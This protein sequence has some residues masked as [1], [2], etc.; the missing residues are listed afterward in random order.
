MLQLEDFRKFII[1]SLTCKIPLLS[2]DVW[3]ESHVTI[4]DITKPINVCFFCFFKNFLILTGHKSSSS[5]S[6]YKK[7][8]QAKYSFHQVFDT[9]RVIVKMSFNYSHDIITWYDATWSVCTWIT[10]QVHSKLCLLITRYV[11]VSL[12]W[13][14]GIILLVRLHHSITQFKLLLMSQV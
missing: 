3:I 7:Q 1:G 11:V 9:Q 6:H 14:V 4:S 5:Y 12:L 13:D 2:W 10:K 8:K